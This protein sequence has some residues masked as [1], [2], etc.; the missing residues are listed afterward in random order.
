ME[1]QK[2]IKSTVYITGAGPGDPN[3]LTLKAKEIIEKADVIAYDNLV[4]KEI[5]ESIVGAYCGKPL[6]I[7]VGKTDGKESISQ[8][9]INNLLLKLSNEYKIV[10][11]LKGGDP[12]IFGRGGEEAEFWLIIIF[13][14]K[15]FQG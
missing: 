1:N 8:E 5:L 14:L 6:L 11:R 2:Q 9:Q 10:C 7:Y 13:L 4:S 15:S 3:L 12:N